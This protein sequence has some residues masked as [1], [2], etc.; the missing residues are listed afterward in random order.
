MDFDKCL[1]GFV[2][3]SVILIIIL[4]SCLRLVNISDNTIISDVNMNKYIDYIVFLAGGVIVSGY[5]IYYIGKMVYRGITC[6][7][8]YDV[9]T[10]K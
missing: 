8:N 4:G 9:F 10:G 5:G 6:K 7:V 3:I 2:V 1:Y